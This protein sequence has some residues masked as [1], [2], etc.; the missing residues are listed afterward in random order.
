MAGSRV[1]QA[2]L[3][4]SFRSTFKDGRCGFCARDSTARWL[5][6]GC[7]FIQDGNSWANELLAVKDGLLAATQL[8]GNKLI[9]ETNAEWIVK[10]LKEEPPPWFLNFL[11]EIFVLLDL[12][13][14]W[15]VLHTFRD[16]NQCARWL[17]S[18]A[19]RSK[20]DSVGCRI[21]ILTSSL[22]CAPMSM[23]FLVIALWVNIVFSLFGKK[24]K[25]L[26]YQAPE[27]LSFFTHFRLNTNE[28]TEPN[29][30]ST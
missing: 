18:F 16:G 4:W 8:G 5:F 11:H 27:S 17:A 3:W 19:K 22:F 9:I 13:I 28:I 7:R 10:V 1:D 2:Q 23:L 15:R 29:I 12:F 20:E 14:E 24:K 25:R 21:S 26:T 6:A 30:C